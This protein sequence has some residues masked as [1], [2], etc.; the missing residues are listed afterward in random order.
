[1]SN[2]VHGA[3]LT[4]ELV[5]SLPAGMGFYPTALHF[6]PNVTAQKITY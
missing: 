6:L 5:S 4:A 1:M 3:T 2:L